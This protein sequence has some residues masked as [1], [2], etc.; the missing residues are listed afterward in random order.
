MTLLAL[1][2]NHK[3][4]SVDLR[5]KV[6]F[7]PEQVR[8]ANKQAVE[9][10]I[11]S[12]IAVVSTCNRTEIYAAMNDDNTAKVSQWLAD[13]HQLD[14]A[15]LSPYLY[16][17]LDEA[18]VVHL[19]RVAAGLDSLVLGE[20]QILGQ[21]KQAYNE[22]REAGSLFRVLDKWFQHSFTVAKQ[23]RSETEIGA[24]AVSVAYAAVSL[25]KQIFA[26][27][28]E[29]NVLLIGA[30]ETIE[31]TAKHLAEQQVSNIFVAN[32]TVERAQ[33][34]AAQFADKVNVQAMALSEIPQYLPQADIVITSTASQL[35][36]LGK[37]AVET[38]LK[39][40]KHQPMLLVDIAVPRDIETQV[41]ELND[42]YLYTVDDLQGIIEQNL[43]ARQKAAVDAEGIIGRRSGEFMA[44]LSSLSSVDNI[45]QYRQRSEQTRDECV[46]AA[47]AKLQAGAEPESVIKELGFKLTN[48]LIHHPTIAL[49]E[50]ARRGQQEQTAAICFALGLE[51]SEIK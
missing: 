46:S 32:R 40:R 23:V 47:L 4:A 27:L 34:L 16:Q 18:A 8:A 25:S 14:L 29:T 30:G 10:G 9:L 49:T 39:Q 22:G 50:S 41:G 51:Q 42:A 1:G 13:F 36:I 44:W 31:L 6:A 38:A 35:P 28:A 7:S 3:T 15:L 26:D 24:N 33:N 21:V 11:A 5:E 37:G 12:E 45:R 43:E 19:N 48:K 20:P 17:H 2:I